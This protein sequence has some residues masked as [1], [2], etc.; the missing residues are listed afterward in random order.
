MSHHITSR[1]KASSDGAAAGMT[2]N[3]AC[4]QG[5]ALRPQPEDSNVTGSGAGGKVLRLSSEDSSRAD[6]SS[7]DSDPENHDFAASDKES[8]EVNLIVM[9][10]ISTLQ[11]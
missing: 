2:G 1:T 10:I 7:R 5:K 3:G 9:C 6:S 4:N 8:T 11:C